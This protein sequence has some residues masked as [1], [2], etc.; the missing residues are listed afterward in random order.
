MINKRINVLVDGAGGDVGQGVLKSLL[1]SELNINLHASCISNSSSWLYKIPN[2]FIF[3]Y[4][5]EKDFIDYLIAFILK[6]KIDI[7]FPT[8]DS[9]LV[10]ISNNKEKIESKTNV[11]IFIDNPKKISICDDKFKTITFLN[12]NNFNS[13]LSIGLGS[14]TEI[15]SFLDENPFP[16]ILKSKS[17]NGAKEVKEVNSLNEVL[18]YISNTQWMLQE[19]LDINHEITSG[20]YIGDDE[21]IKSIYILKRELKAG[22][23]YKAFRVFDKELENELIQIAKQMN[24]KYINIQAVYKDKKLYPFEFN[25]RMSGTTGAMRSIFNVAENFIKE[26][27]FKEHIPVCTNKEPLYLARYYEEVLYTQ[28][29]ISLLEERSHL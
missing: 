29:D 12:E 25:G 18:P 27:V 15:E 28:D 13:P 5:D 3:P 26:V 10:K 23:T 8:I 7:Y 11:K 16:L 17:G 22:S 4:V 20:I 9:S 19:K 6:Y 24:M 21:E 2:S 14:R 1:D